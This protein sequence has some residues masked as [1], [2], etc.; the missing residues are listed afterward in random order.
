ME[1]TKGQHWFEGTVDGPYGQ[2]GVLFVER[3]SD[4]F[5]AKYHRKSRLYVGSIEKRH[6]PLKAQQET[7]PSPKDRGEDPANDKA[8]DEY[9]RAYLKAARVEVRAVLDA[10]VAGGLLR[11]VPKFSFSRKAGC[12]CPCSPGFIIDGPPVRLPNGRPVDV[13]LA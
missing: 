11:E 13:S 9:N 6:E 10:L 4:R 12:S 2:I 8:Y 1:I 7:L 5:T 3:E